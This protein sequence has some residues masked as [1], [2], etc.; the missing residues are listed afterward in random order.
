MRPD[1]IFVSFLC[2]FFSLRTLSGQQAVAGYEC[3]VSIDLVSVT[4]EKDRVRVSITPPP[5][6]SRRI[7]YVLPAYLPSIGDKVDVGQFV[8]QFY[9]LDDRGTPLKAVKKQGGNVILLKL[10]KGRVLRKL[11]YW[12][13]DSWDESE[14]KS[15]HIDNY[16]HVPNANGTSFDSEKGFLLNTAFM[17]GYFDGYSWIP[18]RVTVSHSADV[19]AFTGMPR[20]ESEFNRDEFFANSYTDIIEF[21][22]Y[23]GKPD[24][25]GFESRNIYLDIAVFSETGN[26]TARQIR[27]YIGAQ[28]SALTR[29]LGDV[30]P[31]HYKMF[32]YF[33]SPE[34]FKVGTKGVFGGVA[35][36]NSAVYYFLESKDEDQ[37]ISLVRRETSGDILK[38]MSLLDQ[39]KQC[40]GDL[41]VPQVTP[42]WWVAEGMKS[43]FTWLADL[44]DSVSSEEEFMAA[45]S[46]RIRLYQEVRHKSLHDFKQIGK[47][48]KDPLVA[49]EYRSKAMLTI[50]LLDVEVTLWSGGAKGLREIALELNDSIGFRADSLGRYIARTISTEIYTFANNYVFGEKELP[51]IESF[52]KIGWVYSPTSLDSI[53]TFGQVS[54]YYDEIADAFFVR[55]A[56]LGNRLRLEAGDRLVSING[57]HV[58]AANIEESLNAIYSPQDTSAVEVIFIRGNQNER[59][60][61]T[62]FFKTM[63][64]DHLVRPDPAAGADAQLL[65]AR[66]FSPFD[67]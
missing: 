15:Y 27:K 47:S 8:H 5:I 49:E 56:D 44:R 38:V 46:A 61:A 17:F 50:M 29:F 10:G 39:S 22:I 54:L 48:M 64:I 67:Y 42:C 45:I 12:I 26:V 57:T 62:P 4:K 2:F 21:P 30:P 13:D 18:Y 14:G 34:N 32:F 40:T 53:L 63:V 59:V 43:Y 31:R 51:L 28:V 23:Y 11:E 6:K 37:L 1:F 36:R 55:Q 20:V 9:A 3:R 19:A 60:M 25:I 66:I 33:A 65:H 24:T 41:L 52:G 7:R 35:H 58:N 16:N